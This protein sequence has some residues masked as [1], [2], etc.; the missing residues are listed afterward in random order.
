MASAASSAAIA[1]SSDVVL[2]E[3]EFFTGSCLK[4]LPKLTTALII[5]RAHLCAQ[6]VSESEIQRKL[7]LRLEEHS[8]G[9]SKAK[10]IHVLYT[11]YIITYI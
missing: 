3:M 5:C 4:T 8:I 9:T 6:F 7:V 10:T 1:Y 11:V 2:T